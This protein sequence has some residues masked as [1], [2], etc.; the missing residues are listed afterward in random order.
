MPAISLASPTIG[1]TISAKSAQ[2]FVGFLDGS[3]RE[4]QR[5]LALDRNAVL[6]PLAAAG[7]AHFAAR[8]RKQGA[9]QATMRTW[10]NRCLPCVKP[11][12]SMPL[13]RS[14]ILPRV[15]YIVRIDCRC[16]GRAD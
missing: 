12:R 16:E 2:L 14:K 13:M 10:V 3:Q 6:L 7:D 9:I 4:G 5:I 1:A 11:S 15:G 8:Q